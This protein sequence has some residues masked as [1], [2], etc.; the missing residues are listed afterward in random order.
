MAR[1][2]HLHD[3]PERFVVGTVGEPGQRTFYLQARSKN[4]LTTV[5]VEKE[6]VAVLAERIDAML[7]EVLR[8]TGGRAVIPAVAPKELADDGPLDQPIIEE[9]RVG[10]LRLAWD[11]ENERV[12]IEAYEVTDDDADPP[13]PVD[14]APDAD[15]PETLVVRITGAQ[16]RAFVQRALAVVAAGR[17]PCP[18]C[19][20]PLDPQ[21]HLC[22][23][24]NGYRRSA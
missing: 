10:T 22:P 18:F 4:L 17:P 7:D 1:V 3:A 20:N 6:Q 12:V 2:V 8:L 5:G 16:A 13:P 9:F 21:G 15:G 23:R 19:G 14:E 24:L 11:N